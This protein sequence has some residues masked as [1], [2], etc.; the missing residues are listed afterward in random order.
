MILHDININ[1][2]TYHLSY[3]GIYQFESENWYLY[4]DISILG[5]GNKTKNFRNYDSRYSCNN[6]HMKHIDYWFLERGI[7]VVGL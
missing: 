6:Q 5:V 2:V 1:R 3:S 4:Q 7:G